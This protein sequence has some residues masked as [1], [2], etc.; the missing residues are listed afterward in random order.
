MSLAAF[1]M[2]TNRSGCWRG[3]TAASG[4]A[5]PG[6]GDQAWLRRDTIAVVRGEVMV[7]IRIQGR[8]VP[9]RPAALRRLAAAAVERLGAATETPG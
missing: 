6:V 8:Q 4:E 3:C 1:S 9:D 7:S 2:L 5:V